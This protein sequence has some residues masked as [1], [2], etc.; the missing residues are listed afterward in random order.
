ML[1]VATLIVVNSVMAGFSTKLKDRLHG[2]LSDV[3]IESPSANGFPM[4]SDLMVAKIMASPAAEHIEAITAT[5]EVPGML[6]FEV[7]PNR[8]RVTIPVQI[9]GTDPVGRTAIGGFGEYLTDPDRRANPNFNLSETALWRWNQFNPPIQNVQPPVPLP[10]EAP[11]LAIPPADPIKPVGAIVGHGIT[12]YRGIDPVTKGPVEKDILPPGSSFK[13][14]MIGAGK[15]QIEPVHSN[16]AVCDSIKTEMTEYDGHFVYVPLD[17][18]Q[19]LRAM[20]NRVTHIQIKLKDYANA[21]GGRRRASA[22][23]RRGR[24]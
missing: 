20:G 14:L 17:Y 5:V 9:V 22:D 24:A 23:F 21:P 16:F 15:E 19:R 7:G 4:D 12:H 18:L 8:E 6:V 1:G 13:L 3:I 10:G 2:I 11:L